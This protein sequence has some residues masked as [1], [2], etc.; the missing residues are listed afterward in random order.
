MRRAGEPVATMGVV[1]SFASSHLIDEPVL[2]FGVVCDFSGDLARKIRRYIT[3]RRKNRFAESAGGA[4][5][6]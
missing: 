4:C 5:L 2:G 1:H 3:T 6:F